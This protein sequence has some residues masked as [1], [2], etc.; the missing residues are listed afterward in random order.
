MPEESLQISQN[1]DQQLIE[2]D[3][4]TREREMRNEHYLFPSER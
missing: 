1:K 3:D 2:S 4:K